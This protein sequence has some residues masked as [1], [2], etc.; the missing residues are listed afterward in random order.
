MTLHAGRYESLRAIASGGMATVYLGRALGAG[1]FERLVAL[2]MMHPHIAAEPEFV[3]MF[4]DEAR[5]AARVRHPNVVATFDLVEDPLFLVMEYIEGPSLHS[6]LRTCARAKRPVPLGIVLRIFLDVLA[7]LH[8]AHELTGSEGEPLNLVHRDVSPQNVLVG[9]DGIARITDF[10]VARAETRLMSTRGNALKGKLAY[11]APEQIRAANVDRRSDVYSAGVVLWEMLTEE[12]LFKADNDGA[13]LAQILQGAPTGPRGVVPSVPAALD[14]ICLRALRTDPDERFPTAAAFAEAL[15]DAATQTPGLAVSSPRAVE[16]LIKEVG[17]RGPPE[18]LTAPVSARGAPAS[19]PRSG[20]S[21]LS[22]RSPLSDPLSPRSP[23]SDRLPLSQRA[24]LTQRSVEAAQDNSG[25]EG[26]APGLGAVVS[27][28]VS[29]GRHHIVRRR[30][31]A[32]ACAVALAVGAGAFLAVGQQEPAAPF[33]AESASVSRVSS[34]FPAA[35]AASGPVQAAAP[36]HP[37]EPAGSPVPGGSAQGV[38]PGGAP[39]SPAPDRSTHGSAPGGPA[40]VPAPTANRATSPAPRPSSR[41]TSPAAVKP[42]TSR[43]DTRTTSGSTAPTA[44]PATRSSTVRSAA[45]K[46]APKAPEPKRSAPRTTF[47]PSGL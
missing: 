30:V 22:Q 45:P 10:G 11:M 6:L 39:Q 38:I 2:K 34:F 15:E 23:L 7:G 9:V 37:G 28:A 32:S 3:A 14:Q 44:K 47:K 35:A 29:R 5:L 1:G 17:L 24:P 12:R 33:T 46:T 27:E 16:A 19:A 18:S 42:R 4:L 8:A 31:L 41:A 40:Q 20:R 26:S 25:A 36:G 13:L 43:P 21:P